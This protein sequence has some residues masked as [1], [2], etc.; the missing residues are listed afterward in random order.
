MYLEEKVP[1]GLF[2]VCL[3]EEWLFQSVNRSDF[4]SGGLALYC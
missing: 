3:P 2:L 1:S 4:F